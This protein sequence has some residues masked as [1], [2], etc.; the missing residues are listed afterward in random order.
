MKAMKAQHFTCGALAALLATA[1]P[2][3]DVVSAG[4][5]AAVSV[6]SAATVTSFYSTYN[7][8]PIWFRGGAQSP[9]GSRLVQILQR[10]VVDGFSSGPALAAQVQ[11]ALAQ[12]ATGKKEDIAAAE[13]V[14][15]TAWVSYVQSLKRPTPGMI[16]AF[17]VLQ[18]QGNRPD[19]IL[20]A[21]AAAPS[22]EQYLD[23]VSAVNPIYSAIR[24]AEWARMQT[25][26]AMPPDPRV[27][28]NLDR[29]R[30]LPSKGRF[31]LVDSATQRL[32]LYE[33][34]VPVDSMKV[35]V[36]MVKPH[37]MPTPLIASYMYYIT[38][39]PYW[40]AP[41]HLVREAIAP[42]TLAGGMKYFKGMGYEVMADWTE[43]SVT[44]PPESVDWKAVAAGKTKLRIR[45]K[46]GKD[47]F[48]GVLKFPFPN[49]QDIYL[50][51]TPAK[52]KFN[53]ASR[54]LSNGCV[55]VEDAKRLG[56]WLLGTDP[57]PPGPEPEIR[58]QAPR[59]LPIYLTYI[60]A[61]PKDGQ[62]TFVKDIYG[63]DKPT[64]GTGAQVAL[65]SK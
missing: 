61:Q 59:G 24:D 20:L 63:W 41:D 17:P 28:A 8:P 42:K 53:L 55:R 12:A 14:L 62:L 3:A 11:G 47:N 7:I 50:H 43:N 16:Y 35:I 60:T 51:D 57:V 32:F 38:Y 44:I 2:A 52:D 30:S 40:N 31:L 10:S 19:Q 13:R 27:I 64:A 4:P 1:A 6:P 39:N 26:G 49:P 58:V 15:S 22:L 46:P 37:Y 56:R 29:V 54:D 23:T 36:G 21:A 5:A 9:A 48:M 65:G 33:N 34:G 45:Q 25:T 18:P